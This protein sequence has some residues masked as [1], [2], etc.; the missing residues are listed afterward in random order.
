MNVEGWAKNGGVWAKNWGVWA[1]SEKVAKSAFCE[2]RCNFVGQRKFNDAVRVV[3]VKDGVSGDVSATTF[4][5]FR[6]SPLGVPDRAAS[7]I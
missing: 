7:L 5:C 4:G 6:V 1:K 2:Q 3:R